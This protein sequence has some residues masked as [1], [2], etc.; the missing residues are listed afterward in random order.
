MRFQCTASS[1]EWRDSKTLSQLWFSHSS[2]ML[3]NVYIFYCNGVIVHLLWLFPRCLFYRAPFITTWKLNLCASF[4]SRSSSFPMI[5]CYHPVIFFFLS[6]GCR[7]FL[8]P[9]PWYPPAAYLSLVTSATAFGGIVAV[10][11]SL[12]CRPDAALDALQ[13]SSWRLFLF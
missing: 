6:F 13:V 2:L 10:A 1:P 4:V 11:V 5:S 9:L 7:D 12:S 8:R 3:E